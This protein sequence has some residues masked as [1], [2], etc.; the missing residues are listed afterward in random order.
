MRIICWSQRLQFLNYVFFLRETIEIYL[1][2][3]FYYLYLERHPTALRRRHAPYQKQCSQN[4]MHCIGCSKHIKQQLNRY[5]SCCEQ[6]FARQVQHDERFFWLLN[7][8]G[9]GKINIEIICRSLIWSHAN[10][11]WHRSRWVQ[12]HLRLLL[13]L[14]SQFKSNSYNAMWTAVCKYGRRTQCCDVHKRRICNNNKRRSLSMLWSSWCRTRVWIVVGTLRGRILLHNAFCH[15]F[16]CSY[17]LVNINLGIVRKLFKKCVTNSVHTFSLD[18]YAILMIRL[19]ELP[20]L[21]L[22]KTNDCDT[23]IFC[24]SD[25]YFSKELQ[26]VYKDTYDFCLYDHGMA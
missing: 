21:V 12:A 15:V 11:S 17:E 16:W 8:Y 2:K 3:C 14:Y 10:M 9:R 1:S 5:A 18:F 25:E 23:S 7:E 4:Q 22:C 20:I 24:G 6:F 19:D 13:R 26:V